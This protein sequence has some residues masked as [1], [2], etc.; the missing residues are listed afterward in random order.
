MNSCTEQNKKQSASA[1]QSLMLLAVAVLLFSANS[2]TAQRIRLNV[3]QQ[4]SDEKINA[5]SGLPTLAE[6]PS[7]KVDE[8]VKQIVAQLDSHSFAQRELAMQS[9]TANSIDRRQICKVL[10]GN[11][12]SLEQRHRLVG[13]LKHDLISTPHAAIGISISSLR[14]TNQAIVVDSLIED[15]PAIEVLMPG[16]QIISLD[17]LPINERDQFLQ[18]I[19]SRKPGDKITITIKRSFEPDDNNDDSELVVRELDFEIVLGSDELLYNVNGMRTGNAL[20]QK[21][22]KRDL[23][24]ILERYGPK[25]L[26]IESGEPSK[27]GN[28]LP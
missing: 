10:S 20:V 28:G 17:G 22:L 18:S 16:D 9:L 5:L 25:I 8:K 1:W 15:L 24:I 12:L 6:I 27:P 21:A 11:D 14:R 2:A 23:V 26:H 19:G 3:L 13:W 4:H 7:I